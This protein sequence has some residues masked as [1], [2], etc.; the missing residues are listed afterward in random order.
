MGDDNRNFLVATGLILAILM[1]FQV[2]FFG[3]QQAERRAEL[4]AQREAE[5]AQQV[6][7]PDLPQ[8]TITGAGPARVMDRDEALGE[9]ARIEI[10]T[11]AVDGTISLTGARFDDLRLLH[12]TT[13]VNGDEPISLLNPIGTEQV[14]YARDGWQ[15]GTQGFGDLPG[16]STQWRVVAGDRLTPDTP[17][18]LGYESESGLSFRRTIRVDADYLFTITDEVTNSTSA[19]VELQR[20]GLVRHEGLPAE[21]TQKDRKSVV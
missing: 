18:V 11:P 9:V 3:P 12:H 10:D 7:D 4:D 8:D 20:Y 5:L 19:E 17:V 1:V 14:F 15:S 6:A 2:F 16:T 13:E 21:L